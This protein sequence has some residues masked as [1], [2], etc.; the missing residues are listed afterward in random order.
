MA[1]KAAIL[2]ERAHLS[3]WRA[4]ASGALLKLQL[5]NTPHQKV[6]T[7][8][9]AGYVMV[10]GERHEKSVIVT[11]EQ[12]T[13]WAAPDFAALDESHFAPL[14]ALQP[15]V[16]LLGTGD[17]L[18]F[19]HPHLYR[20]LIEARIGVECMDTAAACRTYNILAAEGRRV[21]AAILL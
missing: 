6:F 15:E 11:P 12:V 2:S 9:G 3:K 1:V 18:R 19:P 7:A 16:L 8:Y 21:A 17:Q 20:S 4:A 14:L 10:N 13:G 5:S